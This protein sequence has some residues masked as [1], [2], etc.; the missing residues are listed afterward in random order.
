M[1][2]RTLILLGGNH[3]ETL[4]LFCKALEKIEIKLGKIVNR[5]SIY[6]SE[7]WGF[8]AKNNFYNIIAEIETDIIPEKQLYQLLEIEKEL[9]RK[10]EC[11][12]GYESRGIDLDILFVDDLI[13]NTPFLI[14]PHPRLHLRRFTLEPLCEKWNEMIHPLLHKSIQVLLEEC[15]D[16]GIVKC[17]G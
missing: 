6:E 12:E 15:K 7:P 4:Q 2:Y 14:V 17:I 9:G 16:A 5:S 8:Y 11:H 13:I 3:P 1:I 10:R